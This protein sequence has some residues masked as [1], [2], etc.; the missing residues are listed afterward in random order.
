MTAADRPSPPGRTVVAGLSSSSFFE[1]EIEGRDP[2]ARRE[3]WVRKSL[4]MV[5]AIAFLDGL[6]NYNGP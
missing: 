5:A 1:T 2:T 3:H 4:Q 6:D